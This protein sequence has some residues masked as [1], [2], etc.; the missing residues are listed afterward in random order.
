MLLVWRENSC[1]EQ[2]AANLCHV[3]HSVRWDA[4]ETITAVGNSETLKGSRIQWICWCKE[5]DF[6]QA[7]NLHYHTTT[8]AQDETD[9]EL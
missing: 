4:G 5:Q 6:C 9:G 1:E 8:N 7:Q 2:G 3:L